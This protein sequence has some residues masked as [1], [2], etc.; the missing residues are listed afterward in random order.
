MWVEGRLPV[1]C[2]PYR[3]P[4]CEMP[5]GCLSLAAQSQQG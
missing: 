3:S 4:W 5:M 2:S 1:G